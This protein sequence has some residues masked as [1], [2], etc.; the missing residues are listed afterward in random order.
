MKPFPVD[1]IQSILVQKFPTISVHVLSKLIALSSNL[2]ASQGSLSLRQLV[3]VCNYVSY[4]GESRIGNFLSRVMMLSVIPDKLRLS[5]LNTI[6]QCG[7]SSTPRSSSVPS[8]E[9][10]GSNVRIGSISLPRNVPKHPELIPRVLFFE[11]PNHIWHLHDLMSDIFAGERY[12]LLIGTQGVGKNKLVDRLLELL[13][14]EREYMQLHRDTSISQLTSTPSLENGK[15]CF[16]DSPLV[17]AAIL[18]RTVV[19]DEADKAPLEVVSILKGLVEDG[20]LLLADGRRLVREYD[21]HSPI[22]SS[23]ASEIVVPIHENFR[24]IVLANRAG[25]PFLGNGIF[26]IISLFE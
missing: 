7:F 16:I 24:M 10:H 1:D 25:Y 6:S 11:I 18:G 26:E 17:R 13:Q 15:L 21:H 4:F 14:L 8:I 23:S 9:I 19:I 22:S 5:I 12:L 20:Q 3:R 2:K